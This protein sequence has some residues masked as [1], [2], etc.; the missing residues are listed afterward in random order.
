MYIKKRFG[1]IEK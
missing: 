1:Q